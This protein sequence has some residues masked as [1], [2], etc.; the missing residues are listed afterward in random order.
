MLSIKEI[1]YLQELAEAEFGLTFSWPKHHNLDHVLD[2]LQRKGPTD[3]YES[4][5]GECLHPQ[6]KND[7]ERSSHQ[8]DTVD[9]QVFFLIFLISYLFLSLI[10]QMTRM[11]QE[12]DSILRI[13]ARVDWYDDQEERKIMANISS[14]HKD[15]DERVCFCAVQPPLRIQRVAMNAANEHSFRSF[16]PTLAKYLCSTVDKTITE[17]CL[18]GC[19]VSP[20]FIFPL[21]YNP[22]EKY[23][24]RR[25]LSMR[26]AYVCLMS[27]SLKHDHVHATPK[28]R[29]SGSRYDFVSINGTN[30]LEFAQT[31]GFYTV[32]V[33]PHVYH[34]ALVR[35]YRSIGHHPSSDY[36]QLQDS[37]NINFVFVDTILGAAHILPPTTFNSVFTVQDLTCPDMY[38]RL[39]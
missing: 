2:L 12:R 9:E 16:I 5:I 18:N 25:H 27:G 29:K 33:Y 30:G 38:L 36:I 32:S 37:K 6:V 14:A 39:Q 7:Y 3:N 31:C 10:S 24:I 1:I 4:G 23:Q 19:S 8:P 13:R 34:I 21:V 15:S 20:H 22:D 26:I 11:A 28:W 35:H 17:M